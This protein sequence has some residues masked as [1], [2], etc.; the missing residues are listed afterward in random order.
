MSNI[1]LV[2]SFYD[3][4]SKLFNHAVLRLEVKSILIPISLML[5][6]LMCIM[7]SYTLS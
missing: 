3:K 6:H 7:T 4:V 1:S 2:K 5:P